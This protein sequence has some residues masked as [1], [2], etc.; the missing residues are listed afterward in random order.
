MLIYSLKP[1]SFA[2]LRT[3]TSDKLETCTE[4]TNA[5]TSRINSMLGVSKKYKW[6]RFH[7]S[8]LDE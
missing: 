5:L 3:R 7:S 2:A 1:D 8:E 6:L 4:I